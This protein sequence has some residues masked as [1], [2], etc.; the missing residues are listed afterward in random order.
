[1][2]VLNSISSLINLYFHKI[3]NNFES[4][5]SSFNISHLSPTKKKKKRYKLKAPCLHDCNHGSRH[6]WTRPDALDHISFVYGRKISS[7]RFVV[8]TS[9]SSGCE[10]NLYSKNAV[11][12]G[13]MLWSSWRYVVL[14]S[15]SASCEVNLYS[16]N[17]VFWDVIPCACCKN[18]RFGG[19]YRLH[20]LHSTAMK[21]S[22]LT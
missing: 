1:M 12:W 22:N 14:K 17:A 20:I 6:A 21:T 3:K 15:G 5:L 4:Y 16:K 10:V 19:N 18:R 13:V 11:F 9:G 2:C 7:W 8:L